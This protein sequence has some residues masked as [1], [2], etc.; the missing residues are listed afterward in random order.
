MFAFDWTRE[1]IYH[2]MAFDT[3]FEYFT[4]DDYIWNAYTISCPQNDFDIKKSK[5]MTPEEPKWY[6]WVFFPSLYRHDS[7]EISIKGSFL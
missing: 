3:R 1:E 6:N 4:F 2:A 5:P 7:N